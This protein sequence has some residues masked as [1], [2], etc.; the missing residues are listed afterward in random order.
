M[1]PSKR[2]MQWRKMGGVRGQRSLGSLDK[3]VKKGLS[4]E[5]PQ[6]KIRIRSTSKSKLC[7]RQERVGTR[8]ATVGAGK[9][10]LAMAK[11]P[12]IAS[13]SCKKA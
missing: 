3:V 7:K 11:M 12:A 10:C 4:K 8:V 9:D 6:G 13:R 1:T 5:G 2:K